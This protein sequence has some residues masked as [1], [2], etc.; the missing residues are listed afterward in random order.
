CMNALVARE[1]KLKLARFGAMCALFRVADP[2]ACQAVS[3]QRR[4][5]VA[6]LFWGHPL[7]WQ[8]GD[9]MHWWRSSRS[10]SHAVKLSEIG[11]APCRERGPS[12][13]GDR[14]ASR[15]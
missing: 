4:D 6:T 11:R 8:M 1:A 3:Q 15:D 2:H 9:L 7:R 14:P 12:S 5:L 10:N 13:G